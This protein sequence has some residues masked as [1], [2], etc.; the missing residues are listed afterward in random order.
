[1]ALRTFKI[2]FILC[3]PLFFCISCSRHSE[4]TL[5][6]YIEGEYTYISSGVSGTLFT[7][8]V[9][10]GQQVTKN[11]L[12]FTLD[13]QPDQAIMDAAFT[14]TCLGVTFYVR[15]R[16]DWRSTHFYWWGC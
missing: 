4:N 8:D 6:G 11:Q 2:L 7:L 14:S 5:Q 9:S 13:P 15:M 1:M 12:L 10:R 3:T 16:H